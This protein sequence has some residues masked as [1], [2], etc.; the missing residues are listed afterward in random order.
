MKQIIIERTVKDIRYEAIDGTVFNDSKECEKYEST[1]AAILNSRYR[2]LVKAT[3]TEY[4]MFKAGSDAYT[5]DLVILQDE[6]DVQTVLQMLCLNNSY[7]SK[8]ENIKKLEEKETILNLAF[9]TGDIVLIYRG[10]ENDNFCINDT[11]ATLTNRINNIVK[12]V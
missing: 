6:E 11:L 4:N 9:K 10:Y 7:Y 1:A 3:V 12:D 2:K 8:S 5:I